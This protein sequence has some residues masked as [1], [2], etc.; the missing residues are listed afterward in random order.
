[1]QNYYK[2][3]MLIGFLFVAGWTAQAQ[4]ASPYVYG[5][6]NGKYYSISV[7]NIKAIRVRSG[8]WIDGIQIVGSAKVTQLA[9]GRGGGM[10]T[11][12]LRPGEKVVGI[13]GTYGRQ[14]V[15][16]L[17]FRTNRG[18]YS[19]T[20]G[21]KGGKAFSYIVRDRSYFVGFRVYAGQYMNGIQVLYRKGNST[22]GG[23]NSFERNKVYIF[24][25]NNYTGRRKGF[26]MGSYNMSQLGIGNDN[27]SSIRVPRGYKVV[28]YQDANFKGATRTI[29]NSLASLNSTWNNRTSSL[30]V[31][32]SKGGGGGNTGNTGSVVY[33]NRPVN[34][35]TLDNGCTNGRNGMN[36]TFSW[37]RKARASY[38]HLRVYRSGS[39]NPF[40]N[41]QRVRNNSY[42]INRRGIVANSNRFGWK[43]KVRAMINGRWTAW[44]EIRNFRVE[45]KNTDCGS[46]GAS[47]N[48]GK[49]SYRV[50][51]KNNSIFV[52]TYRLTYRVNGQK[53]VIKK[54]KKAPN[55]SR[56]FD[57]PANATDVKVTI[58]YLKQTAWAELYRQNITLRRN[59]CFNVKTKG[60]SARLSTDCR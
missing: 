54:E 60:L 38:Y 1:M 19:Q 46:S 55:W 36:W 57:V 44:S 24:S 5:K 14:Y 40:I 43:W 26:K 2:A 15:T 3:F 20:F 49:S 8:D 33:L 34:N 22:G 48:L 32:L 56:S 27:L 6:T 17:Q 31:M 23:N 41:E 11:F 13:Y 7:N 9:G 37:A 28:L 39:A 50:M 45:P 52:V 42:S 59:R 18:R 53:R 10:R 30:Q 58:R 25:G 4:T 29:Y 47:S 16:S 12:T 21:K 51:F 35:A